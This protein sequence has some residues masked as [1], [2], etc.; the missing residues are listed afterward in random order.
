M[1]GNIRRMRYKQ[2][3]NVSDAIEFRNVNVNKAG[4]KIN[5]RSR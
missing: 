3:K 2:K 1:Q 5:Q 4:L